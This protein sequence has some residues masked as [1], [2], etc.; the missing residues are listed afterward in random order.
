MLESM[1]V[2][3]CSI[4]AKWY[5]MSDMVTVKHGKYTR[6]YCDACVANRTKRTIND[7]KWRK[8]NAGKN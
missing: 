7:V 8:T 4:C 2:K 6:H 1:G 5:F 3:Q